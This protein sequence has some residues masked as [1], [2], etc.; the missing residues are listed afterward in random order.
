MLEEQSSKSAV[1]LQHLSDKPDFFSREVH[2][3]GF[4]PQKGKK[5]KREHKGAIE[6]L[7]Q[8]ALEGDKLIPLDLSHK[9]KTSQWVM[10]TQSITSRFSADT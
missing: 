5:S 10:T 9:D 6:A 3:T 1:S 4:F 7:V 8:Q 2:T